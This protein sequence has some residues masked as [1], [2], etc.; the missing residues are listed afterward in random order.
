MLD[1][2]EHVV[3]ACREL[4]GALRRGAPGV[5]VLATSRAVLQVPGE[6]VVRLQP[7]PV[8]GDATD[9]AALRRQPSVRAFVEHA[10]RRR[11][12]FELTEEEAPDLIEVLRRL[13]G[14]P[15]GERLI[16]LSLDCR[17]VHEH[18]PPPAIRLDETVPF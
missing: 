1:N 16:T 3:E 14:L 9:L 12:D 8:P 15:L 7:L 17:I 10:R 6:Y 18:V 11:T 2:C 5:R 4:V 13:D